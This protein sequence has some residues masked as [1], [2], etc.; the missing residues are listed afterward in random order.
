ME[1]YL[2]FLIGRE[3]YALDI[4]GVI[5]IVGIQKIT[6]MPQQPNYV[7]GTINL[8]G[9]I[10]PTIDV[11]AKFGKAEIPYNE[12][13]CIIVVDIAETMVGFI[14]DSV[15]EVMTIDET[16][17]SEIPQK[18]GVDFKEKYLKGIVKRE[19]K[20]ILLLEIEKLVDEEQL[21]QIKELKG[22]E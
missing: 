21:R 9:R 7:K 16:T 2:S 15:D 20:V 10:I 18:S 22:I 6:K 14:V 5:E 13:T 8:R 12:R 4:S 17:I 19:H 3:F 1:Q 11:R